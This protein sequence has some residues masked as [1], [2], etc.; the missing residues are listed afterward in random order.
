MSGYRSK[1]DNIIVAVGD[2]WK[3]IAALCAQWLQVLKDAYGSWKE[4]FCSLC[5]AAAD[6]YAVQTR[7]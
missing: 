4:D 1:G 2:V 7:G 6:E 3:W 5:D